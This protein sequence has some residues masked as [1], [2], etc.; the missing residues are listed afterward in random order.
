MAFVD[1]GHSKTCITIASF[2][3]GRIKILRQH[4]DR[5]LGARNMDLLLFEVFAQEFQ[6]KFGLNLNENFRAKLKMFDA[7]EKLR[8]RLTANKEAEIEIEA[9]MD[10]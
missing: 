10:D 1:F 7:I 3:Q 8:T 9:L 5:N 2:L 4:S 6:K